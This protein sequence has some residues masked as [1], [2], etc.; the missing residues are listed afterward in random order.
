MIT[1]HIYIAKGS[2]SYASEPPLKWGIFIK[3]RYD[4]LLHKI[5]VS[6]MVLYTP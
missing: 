1:G 2:P 6:F 4:V 3:K 5:A